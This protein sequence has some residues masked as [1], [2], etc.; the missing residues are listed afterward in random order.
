MTGRGLRHAAVAAALLTALAGCGV[1]TT[2]VIDVGQ[3]ATGAKR[4]GEVAAEAKLYF[5]SPTGVT[6]VTR[7][8]KA[9]LGAEDAIV[10]LLEG[11]DEDQRIRGL[12]TDVPKMKGEV[13]VTTG[14]LRVGIQMPYNVLRLSP[15]ARS[16]F[17]CTAAANEV[18]RGRQIHDVKVE[19]SGGGVVISDLVCDSNNAFPAAKVPTPAPTP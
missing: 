9:K 12:Y 6:Q 8:A 18:P 3:P 7:P 11:P 19:L 1:T 14:T 16:Q 4:Q 5:M 17:V 10:L 13:H 2:D 15:V